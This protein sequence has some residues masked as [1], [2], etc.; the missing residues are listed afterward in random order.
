MSEPIDK[1]LYEKVKREIYK[2]NPQHSAYRSGLLVKEYKRR[3]GRYKGYTMEKGERRPQAE[4]GGLKRWFK[5]D[6]R[7]QSGKTTYQKKGDIFRPTKR[8]SPSTPITM[9]ELTKKEKKKASI[10]KEKTGRVKSFK[11]IKQKF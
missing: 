4:L 11:E 7:T 10:E 9:S 5:E 2:K 8:V 1:I 3:G 6:W